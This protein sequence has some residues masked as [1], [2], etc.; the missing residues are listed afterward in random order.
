MICK[1][2]RIQQPVENID[3][4]CH[5]SS[6]NNPC[7]VSID[8]QDFQPGQSIGSF[9]S[10]GLHPWFINRQDVERALEKIVLSMNDPKLLAIGECGLDKIGQTG[11][12][13]SYV[14]FAK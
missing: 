14:T 6:E 9:Y 5:T 1:Q 8:T 12:A 2:H 3:I 4:H 7:I 10:L 11:F 13:I